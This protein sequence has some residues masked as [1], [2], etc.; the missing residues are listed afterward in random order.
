MSLY[1]VHGLDQKKITEAVKAV[2]LL[3][4]LTEAKIADEQCEYLEWYLVEKRRT[5]SLQIGEQVTIYFSHTG[6]NQNE[7]WETVFN[8]S[9][10]QRTR[11]QVYEL[12]KELRCATMI[13]ELV[14]D[15]LNRSLENVKAE[16]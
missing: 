3:A 4:K 13:S 8:V 7:K 12:Q 9:G 1:M 10:F 6:S 15:R 14:I 16:A 5:M 11:E 2:K